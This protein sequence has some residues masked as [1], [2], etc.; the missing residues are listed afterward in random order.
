MRPCCWSGAR[1]SLRENPAGGRHTGGMVALLMCTSTKANF[2]LRSV[3]PDLTD[4]FAEHHDAHVWKCLQ[5]IIGSSG[6]LE[7]GKDTS[8]L[9]FLFGRLGLSSA[10]R[11]LRMVNRRQ[12][13]V[14]ETMLDGMARSP[15]ECFRVVRSCAQTSTDAGFEMPP[16]RQLTEE[17]QA[18]RAYNPEPNEPQ[19]GWQ[20]KACR[21]RF[22]RH[23]SQSHNVH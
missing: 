7:T 15:G 20:Q 5:R 4:D 16:W 21:V 12:P 8:S 1:D 10:M 9:P 2:W 18:V 3:N 23:V 13:E 22:T 6:G 11:V 17:V 14:A 19:F